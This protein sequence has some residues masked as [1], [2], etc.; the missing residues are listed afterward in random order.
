MKKG[1]L[2][3]ISGPSGVGKGTVI[4]SLLE[5]DDMAYSV[6]ATTRSP[7]PGEI[8]GVD[9]NYITKEE[10]RTLIENGDVLEYAEYTGNY[11][12]T[13][14]KFVERKLN[15]GKSV[16]LEIETC[17]AMQIKKKMPEAVLIFICPPSLEELESRLR[18]RGTETEEVILRRLEQAKK[19]IVLIPE[20]DYAVVNE[21]GGWKKAADDVR[22]IVN[23][24]L[25]S[26]VRCEYPKL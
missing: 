6:S 11:Y 5:N 25:H 18:G 12:G 20:Y 22:D 8:D 7:R 23:A 26:T 24:E 2:L 19:E 10:F 1:L 16:I 17:G 14:R 3:V 21:N 4:D 13:P 15:E 9:Y